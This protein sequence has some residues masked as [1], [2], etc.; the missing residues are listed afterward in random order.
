MLRET[1]TN[2]KG[3]VTNSVFLESESEVSCDN[4]PRPKWEGFVWEGCVLRSHSV[5]EGSQGRNP[6]QNLEA[7]TEGSRD[8]RGVPHRPRG[9]TTSG[10]GPL[11]A[12]INQENALRLAYRP[13]W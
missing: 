9:S 5:T 4:T 6:R 11:I 13:L 1:G 8:H 2:D 3:R 12:I 7:K 10:L